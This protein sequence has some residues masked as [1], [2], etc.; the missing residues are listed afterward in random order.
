MYIESRPPVESENGEYS[1][2]DTDGGEDE[3]VDE[4]GNEDE[5]EHEGE[6]GEEVS[7]LSSVASQGNDWVNEAE[8]GSSKMCLALVQGMPAFANKEL[9]L[10][11]VKVVDHLILCRQTRQLMAV[12]ILPKMLSSLSGVRK[13]SLEVWRPWLIFGQQAPL[14][15]SQCK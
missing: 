10:S 13:L 6:D 14:F 12:A 8:N 15:L 7:D 2:S 1:D 4:D 5:D 9:K 3:D 11:E